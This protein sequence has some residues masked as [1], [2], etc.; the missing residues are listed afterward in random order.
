MYL[1]ILGGLILFQM[2]GVNSLAQES[3]YRYSVNSGLIYNQIK[4]T[5]RV[6]SVWDL[7]IR[8][9]SVEYKLGFVTQLWTD[10][11]ESLSD[12]VKLS[13]VHLGYSKILPTPKAWLNLELKSDVMFQRFKS[14]WTS[15]SWDQGS[16]TYLVNESI[17]NENLITASVGYGLKITISKHLYLGQS[18]NG[19][20]Y[21]SGIKGNKSSQAAQNFDFRRYKNFGLQWSGQFTIGYAFVLKKSGD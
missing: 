5:I 12:A 19:G 15:N 14:A 1:R 18:F 11:A 20:F 9:N 16:G 10:N 17:S 2:L 7:G 4:T 6:A 21:F 8:K 13:G 3:G